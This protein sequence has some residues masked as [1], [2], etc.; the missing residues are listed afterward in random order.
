MF[1]PH[2]KKL[3]IKTPK[4]CPPQQCGGTDTLRGKQA[5]KKVFLV[6][7]L[8][9]FIDIKALLTLNKDYINLLLNMKDHTGFLG[10][11]EAAGFQI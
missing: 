1:K 5:V 9:L 7:K 4:E 10:P 2:S 6:L 3:A 8:Q 11:R